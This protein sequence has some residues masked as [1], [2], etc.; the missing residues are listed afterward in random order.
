MLCV[1]FVELLDSLPVEV[2]SASLASI[3]KENLKREYR[4]ALLNFK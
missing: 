3:R 1:G 4:L 2:E